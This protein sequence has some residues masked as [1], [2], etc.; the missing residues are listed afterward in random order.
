MDTAYKYLKLPSPSLAS[1]ALY[2]KAVAIYFIPSL[3]S[4]ILAI[5]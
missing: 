5:L 2:I 1:F 4:T 3:S